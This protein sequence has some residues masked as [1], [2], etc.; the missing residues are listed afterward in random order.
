MV[1]KVWQCELFVL[2]LHKLSSEMK[3]RFIC[4][5]CLLAG[6][7]AILM[8]GMLPHCHHL[9]G[10]HCRVEVH[11]L[12]ALEDH[13]GQHDLHTGL[14]SNDEHGVHIHGC[15]HVSLCVI[16][17]SLANARQWLNADITKTFHI[18]QILPD[19]NSQRFEVCD[20]VEHLLN[21]YI[22]CCVPLRAPPVC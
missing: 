16:A 6:L 17:Q 7:T 4:T 22:D 15:G 14:C 13:S 21:G 20:V 5:L 9:E 3:R 11:A 8:H 19:I 18:Q 10:S 12:A 1:F 2:I